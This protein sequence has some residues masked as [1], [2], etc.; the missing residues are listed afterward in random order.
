MN[1]ASACPGGLLYAVRP[2]QTLS[3]IAAMFS[4]SV[5]DLL[6]ANPGVD[7]ERLQVGQVLCIPGVGDRVCRRG[8]LRTVR[9]S[10]SLYRI[11]QEEGVGLQELI[12]A[13]YWLPDPN[14]IYPNEQ[15]CVPQAV[16]EA[17]CCIVLE[18]TEEA[19]GTDAGGVALIEE[20][21][22]AS[23]ITFAV[24]G[25]PSPATLGPFDI[26]VGDLVFR[27]I[28]RLVLLAR[29]TQPNQQVTWSGTRVVDVPA[30]AANVVAVFPYNTTTGQRG[31]DLLMGWVVDCC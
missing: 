21:D 12:A 4:V 31:P 18:R 3:R 22:D 19:G 30:L 14:V 24:A 16:A 20:L 15:I 17:G 5:T 27:E 1:T 2:G 13:N 7:P 10:D 29:C 9:P 25:L 8:R 26:Y 11:A 6:N 28:E 23:R